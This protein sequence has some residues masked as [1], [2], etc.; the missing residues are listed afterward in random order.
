MLFARDA[1]DGSLDVAQFRSGSSKLP[2]EDDVPGVLGQLVDR[3]GQAIRVTTVQEP[4]AAAKSLLLRAEGEAQKLECDGKSARLH[5]AVGH[6]TMVFKIDDPTKVT[7]RH[8]GEGTFEFQCGPQ[9][10]F[11]V[12]VEYLPDADKTKRVAGVLRVLEF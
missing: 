7:L 11:H 8:S 3:S 5:V 6:E 2:A 1:P 10:P 12:V 9:K 4:S